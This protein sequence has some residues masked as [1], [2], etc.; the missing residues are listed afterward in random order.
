VLTFALTASILLM[1]SGALMT[2]ISSIRM[3][4][5]YGLSVP[6]AGVD[7]LKLSGLRYDSLESC[8]RVGSRALRGLPLPEPMNFHHV[9]AQYIAG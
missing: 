1:T 9:S 6:S 4:L 7:F 3:L 2:L 8:E 5:S